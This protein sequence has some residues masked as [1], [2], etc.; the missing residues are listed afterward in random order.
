[1]LCPAL[2]YN[3][4]IRSRVQL[5]IL[6][7]TNK[8]LG[9]LFPSSLEILTSESAFATFI[10]LAVNLVKTTFLFVAAGMDESTFSRSL[11]TIVS[12]KLIHVL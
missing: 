6:L 3:L 12:E 11:K 1:M 2:F 4:R 8:G 7:N 5:L 10:P 9:L